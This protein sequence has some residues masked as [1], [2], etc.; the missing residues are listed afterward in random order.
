MRILFCFC[1]V[2]AFPSFSACEEGLQGEMCTGNSCE[3]KEKTGPEP[4]LNEEPLLRT[5]EED[6]TDETL[7]PAG[8]KKIDQTNKTPGNDP[9]DSWE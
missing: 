4:V 6:R 7:K 8:L 9:Y 3:I 2:L 1:L 5:P